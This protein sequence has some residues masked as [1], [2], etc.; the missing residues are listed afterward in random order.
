MKVFFKIFDT[1]AD[2]IAALILVVSTGS[3]GGYWLAVVSFQGY[4][5]QHIIEY[6]YIAGFSMV[7]Q[8]AM[9]FIKYRYPHLFGKHEIEFGNTKNGLIVLRWA[10]DCLL[11]GLV[12]ALIT[13]Y[14]IDFIFA[15][16]A[17]IQNIEPSK[18]TDFHKI[19]FGAVLIG[20]SYETIVKK[21]LKKKKEIENN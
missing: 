10:I 5:Q 16:L 9:Y 18:E 21:Y 4:L 17:F 19:I 6:I 14:S 3:L 7:G 20:A 2:A 12:G 11:A 1:M 8:T 13:E 15:T